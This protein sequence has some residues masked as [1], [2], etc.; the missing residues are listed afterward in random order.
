MDAAHDTFLIPADTAFGDFTIS[1]FEEKASGL[2]NTFQ[3]GLI[4]AAAALSWI[5][6]V[7]IVVV[8]AV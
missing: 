4:T 5:G 6:I 7:A 3:A 1:R 8:I 2:V